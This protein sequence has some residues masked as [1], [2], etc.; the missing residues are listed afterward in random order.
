MWF[1]CALELEYESLSETYFRALDEKIYYLRKMGRHE[2]ATILIDSQIARAYSIKF[3]ADIPDLVFADNSVDVHRLYNYLEL[4]KSKWA[5]WCKE[6]QFPRM[7]KSSV[8]V[9]TMMDALDICKDIY[10][11]RGRLLRQY[12]S[13][14]NFKYQ[15]YEL[16]KEDNDDDDEEE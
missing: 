15:D 7:Y 5:Q 1:N 11:E 4:Y 13:L 12:L 6:H 8:G 9:I 14:K 3:L 10:T 2:E 16:V